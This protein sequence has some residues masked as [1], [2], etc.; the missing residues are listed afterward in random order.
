M[1]SKI[2]TRHNIHIAKKDGTSVTIN[3]S[4]AGIFVV[5]II[6]IYLF[7]YLALPTRAGSAQQ[8]MPITVRPFA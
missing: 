3:S 2:I 1:R 7:V 5:I 4:H 6:S 8:H